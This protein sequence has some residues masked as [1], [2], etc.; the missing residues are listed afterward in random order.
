[1]TS[2]SSFNPLRCLRLVV[3][4]LGLAVGGAL[5]QGLPL[6]AADPGLA[7]GAKAPDIKV[8]NQKGEDTTLQALLAKGNVALVFHRSADW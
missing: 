4:G 3:T 1:M 2:M 5:F 6:Q 8:K 7:I